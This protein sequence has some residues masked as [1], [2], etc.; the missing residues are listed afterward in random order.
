M[1]KDIEKEVEAITKWI[2]AYV[3]ETKTEEKEKIQIQ[4]GEAYP[5]S[6]HAVH[7]IFV[8][9]YRAILRFDGKF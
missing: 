2:K 6:Y 3:E 7:G 9:F 4:T 5:K 1:I 8:G